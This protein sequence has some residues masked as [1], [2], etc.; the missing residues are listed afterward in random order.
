M[1]LKKISRALAF[2]LVMFS[3]V[4]A[5]SNIIVYKIANKEHKI[6]AQT[7]ANGLE[8]HDYVVAKNQD[9]NGPYIKQFKNSSFYSYN[10][11]SVYKPDFAKKMVEENAKT[12]IF[13]P[14]SVAVYQKKKDDNIYIALLS[15]SA[16]K[17]V[18]RVKDKSFDDLEET[19]KK[20]IQKIFPSAKLIDLGYK[21]TLTDKEFF[22]K[23]SI[24]S[25]DED[26]NDEYDDMMMVMQGS[27]KMGGF[28]V[29]NYIDY[30]AKL[31]EAGNNDYTFYH[32]FSLC[33]LKIIYELSKKTPEAG[34]F[35]PCTMVI[36]HKKGSNKTEIV[37]L[38]INSLISMLALKDKDLLTMLDSTQA[39]MVGIIGDAVE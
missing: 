16:Q 23:Y 36:Y 12:G 27:M 34:A 30:N 37:S 39:D 28:V 11:M 29:A 35:A 18:V 4:Q 32:S 26:A 5:N 17:R 13:V 31:K 25:E 6:S 10:L 38:N 24:E 15:A 1:S 20:T 22:T 9:M 3:Y 33:K 14:F 7:V 21:S 2:I 19:N 8:M